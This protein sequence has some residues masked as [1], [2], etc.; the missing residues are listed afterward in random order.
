MKLEV[1]Q[2]VDPQVVELGALVAWREVELPVV[3]SVH[4]SLECP[5][6]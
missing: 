6:P 3:Q 1:A 5:E 4:L 2:E